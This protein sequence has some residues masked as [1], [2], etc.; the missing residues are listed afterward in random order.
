[1]NRLPAIGISKNAVN[2]A[3]NVEIIVIAQTYEEFF[4]L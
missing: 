3:L 4:T 1:M 2:K